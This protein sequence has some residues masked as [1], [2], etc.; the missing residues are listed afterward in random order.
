M[1]AEK[2][3]PFVLDP[4]GNPT[5]IQVDSVA[6]LSQEGS[7]VSGTL[8][9]N[10]CTSGLPI[11]FS[12][13]GQLQGNRLMISPLPVFSTEPGTFNLEV[14][15]SSDLATIQGGTTFGAYECAQPDFLLELTGHLVPSVA[16]KWTGTV[17][18]VNGRTANILATIYETGPAFDGFPILT[19]TALF[20]NS[21][22]FT[23]G[24]LTGS[25]VGTSISGTI[26]TTNGS[27]EIGGAG[28]PLYSSDQLLLN[29]WVQG[30]TC[31]GD[32]AQAT[33]TRQ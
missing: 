29:Y 5:F 3:N 7:S 4:N 1:S 27:I 13:S 19:G 6:Y 12:F 32:Y 22:C 10:F 9:S 20:S 11:T 16:G 17:T 26:D 33:L 25:Q 15:F 28:T 24:T 18:S 8:T 21:P 2:P 30:G 31:N 23:S 14:G